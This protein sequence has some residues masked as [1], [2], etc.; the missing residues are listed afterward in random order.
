MPRSEGRH[1]D[2]SRACD[3]V[4]TIGELASRC[5]LNARTIRYYER[6]GLLPAPPRT[7]AG[8]R[9]YRDAERETLGFIHQA[10]AVGLT[11]DEIVQVLAIR[12]GG[13][14]PCQHVLALID[15]KLEDIARQQ[16][17]L[18]ALQAELEALRQTTAVQ[19]PDEARVCA[20]IE[21]HF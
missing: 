15:Q 19:M 10:K 21:H 5:G 2:A 16:I 1:L 3:S 7:P 17:A 12:R 13:S 4:M 20:L 9:I 6:I 14:P 8:Y 18:A 11:L